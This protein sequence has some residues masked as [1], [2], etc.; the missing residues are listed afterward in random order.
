MTKMTKMHINNVARV[1]KMNKESK[2]FK[3]NQGG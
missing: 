1:I 3:M 2:M